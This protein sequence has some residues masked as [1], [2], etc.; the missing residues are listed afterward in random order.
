[1]LQRGSAF[2]AGWRLAF[3]NRVGSPPPCPRQPIPIR[4]SISC[5]IQ[6]FLVSCLPASVPCL[7]AEDCNSS[8]GPWEQPRVFKA[9]HAILGATAPLSSVGST[10]SFPQG[11]KAF[12]NLTQL[13]LKAFIERLLH[14]RT[15]TECSVYVR[16]F[17]FH[18]GLTR[19]TMGCL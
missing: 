9:C 17:Q 7:L 12:Q 4:V 5:T 18:H 1:M 15:C 14:D 2:L 6:S 8:L 11:T 13:M 10:T 3:Y 16:P 19:G